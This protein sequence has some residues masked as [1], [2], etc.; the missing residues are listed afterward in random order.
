MSATPRNDVIK[1]HGT[2]INTETRLTGS[3]CHCRVHVGAG[4]DENTSDRK[5]N[6]NLR[7]KLHGFLGHWLD[8]RVLA[9]VLGGV[10]P[11]S[12]V[13]FRVIVDPRTVADGPTPIVRMESHD[14]FRD[15]VEHRN[16]PVEL[17]LRCGIPSIAVRMEGIGNTGAQEI[18]ACRRAQTGDVE[19]SFVK[20]AAQFPEKLRK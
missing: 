12:A 18:V 5:D 14:V 9:D 4:K 2:K 17:A 1:I 7:V 6:T 10:E 15:D 19:I 16:P 20:I 8:T 3:V 13:P 11:A